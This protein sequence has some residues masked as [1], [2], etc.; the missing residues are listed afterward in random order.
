MELYVYCIVAIWGCVKYHR[1]EERLRREENK[2]DSMRHA[3]HVTLA[4]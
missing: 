2:T 3:N 4:T 1:K